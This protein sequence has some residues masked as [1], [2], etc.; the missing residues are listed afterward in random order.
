MTSENNQQTQNVK[1]SP[2]VVHLVSSTDDKIEMSVAAA[3]LSTLLAEMLE[4]NEDDTLIVPLRDISTETLLKIVQYS[5][6]YKDKEHIIGF[7]TSHIQNKPLTEILDEW[8]Y[9]FLKDLKVKELKMI[10]V[11]SNFLDHKILMQEA[12]T[13]MIK[14]IIQHENAIIPQTI[15]NTKLTRE[16]KDALLQYNIPIQD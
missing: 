12:A 10:L 6:H 7:K 11:A 8:N 13:T 9:D 16:E 5:E 2:Q 3:K 15:R 1:S 4:N 14:R